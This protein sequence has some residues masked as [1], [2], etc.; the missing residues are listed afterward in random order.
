LKSV[1]NA[2]PAAVIASATL[3]DVAQKEQPLGRSL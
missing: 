1:S 3:C 2:Y